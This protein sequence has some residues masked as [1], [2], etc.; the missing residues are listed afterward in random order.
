MREAIAHAIERRTLLRLALLAAVEKLPAKAP[1]RPDRPARKVVLA[2]I[3]GVRRKETLAATGP[4][5]IPRLR[6]ELMPQAGSIKNVA[7]P[8]YFPYMMIENPRK[9]CGFG[10]SELF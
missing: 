5:N 3:A 1:A 7:A 4:D 8:P 6:G 2:T 10:I 9:T